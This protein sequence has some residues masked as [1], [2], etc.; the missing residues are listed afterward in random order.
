MLLL[1]DYNFDLQLH[2]KHTNPAV[3]LTEKKSL[4]PPPTVICSAQFV[5]HFGGVPRTLSALLQLLT[6]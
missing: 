1:M 4:D 6:S 5:S 2:R 3:K